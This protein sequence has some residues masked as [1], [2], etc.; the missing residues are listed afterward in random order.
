M[1]KGG[2]VSSFVRTQ[3]WGIDDVEKEISRSLITEDAGPIG[4]A[5]THD[6]TGRVVGGLELLEMG[7]GEERDFV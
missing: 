2:F 6:G 1:E 3:K 7:V 5:I 4:Q